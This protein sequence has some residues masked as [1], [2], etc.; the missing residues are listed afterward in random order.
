MLLNADYIHLE[1]FPAYVLKLNPDERV[2]QHLKQ[3]ELCH[4]CCQ[5]LT[6]LGTE[7]DRAIRRIHNRPELIQFFFAG[8]ELHL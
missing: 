3:V 2:W 7:L 5:N 4:L 8:A 6:Q 1:R